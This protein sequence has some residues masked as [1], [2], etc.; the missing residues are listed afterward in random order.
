[1]DRQQLIQL[2]SNIQL[3]RFMTNE[4]RIDSC[5]QFNNMITDIT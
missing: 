1:M 2:R 4:L 5:S 3:L